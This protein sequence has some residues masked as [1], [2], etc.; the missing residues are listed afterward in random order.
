MIA[1]NE[2]V[3]LPTDFDDKAVYVIDGPD[4][5]SQVVASA[6]EFQVRLCNCVIYQETKSLTLRYSVIRLESAVNLEQYFLHVSQMQRIVLTE[7]AADKKVI[8]CTFARYILKHYRNSGNY[9]YIEHCGVDG[10]ML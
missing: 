9:Y 7:V 10:S 6:E 3:A 8:A 1:G 4:G 5:I 2:A